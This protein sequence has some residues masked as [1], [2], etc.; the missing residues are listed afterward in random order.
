MKELNKYGFLTSLLLA[1]KDHLTSLEMFADWKENFEMSTIRQLTVLQTLT[2]V[3]SM[4]HWWTPDFGQNIALEYVNLTLTG[5]TNQEYNLDSTG[6]F[7]GIRNTLKSLTIQPL[8][9]VTL[10]PLTQFVSLRHAHLAGIASR[11]SDWLTV[12]I[13]NS[14]RTLRLDNLPSISS[15]TIKNSVSPGVYQLDWLILNFNRPVQ[16]Q[17]LTIVELPPSLTNLRIEAVPSPSFRSELI[18]GSFTTTVGTNLVSLALIGVRV[19]GPLP[20]RLSNNFE[21]TYLEL[22]LAHISTAQLSQTFPAFKNSRIRTFKASGFGWTDADFSTRFCASLWHTQLYQVSISGRVPN[23]LKTASALT[24]LNQTGGPLATGADLPSSLVS[25]VLNYP[26][27]PT[28]ATTTPAQQEAHRNYYLN[29]FLSYSVNT[30]LLTRLSILNAGAN[31]MIPFPGEALYGL[32]FSL[33]TLEL[34]NA[35]VYGTIPAYFFYNMPHLQYIDVEKNLLT[36]AFPGIA[37]GSI[38]EIKARSNDFD[39]WP[40]PEYMGSLE[41]VDFAYNYRLNRIPT[42]NQW[43]SLFPVL[44]E[45]DLSGTSL[46][47]MWG[48]RLPDVFNSYSRIESFIADNAGF[49]GPF[50]STLIDNT[51]LKVLSLKSNP[52]ICGPL[53]NIYDPTR[54]ALHTLQMSGTRISSFPS[55]LSGRYWRTFDFALANT[56][57][58]SVPNFMI[59]STH[60]TFIDL[61]FLSGVNGE[62]FDLSNVGKSWVT[63]E[64]TIVKLAHTN[65]AMCNAVPALPPAGTF[66][67]SLSQT[68]GCNNCPTYWSSCSTGCFEREQKEEEEV[69]PKRQVPSAPCPSYFDIVPFPDAVPRP[70]MPPPTVWSPA[71]A[72]PPPSPV[73]SAAPTPTGPYCAPPKPHPT[74]NCSQPGLWSVPG[75][76]TLTN[77]VIP[78]RTRVEIKGDLILS[79]DL[80]FQG[81]GNTQATFGTSDAPFAQLYVQKCIR[82]AK[83]L[84]EDWRVNIELQKG[85]IEMLETW[86]RRDFVLGMQAASV[87]SCLPRQTVTPLSGLKFKVTGRNKKGCKRVQVANTAISSGSTTYIQLAAR[88]DKTVCNILMGVLIPLGVIIFVVFVVAWCCVRRKMRTV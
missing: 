44:R 87:S 59:H 75:N 47:S 1:T 6:Y 55:T 31:M 66:Y 83:A 64:T 79:G 4:V 58:G 60:P 23:C 32:K 56:V 20:A 30:P 52:G 50:P 33:G 51:A 43:I 36:G 76:V 24:H 46:G 42:G 12:N 54:H 49:N 13:P 14:L 73:M 70:P 25:Y 39:S 5:H 48:G 7:W 67:C 34:R 18:W 8:A 17:Q 62:M 65:I 37:A 86:P 53:P 22:S 16:T 11:D 71:G 3:S 10:N 80:T 61:T 38:K 84:N 78:A 2:A 26:V 41:V 57:S 35:S 69:D 40:T 63:S 29:A 72:T 28:G 45:V 19:I 27:A 88:I 81:W 74:A 9:A 68:Q 21:L 85:D 77:L 82:I 15:A